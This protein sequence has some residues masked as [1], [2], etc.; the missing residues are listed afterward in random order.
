LDFSSKLRATNFHV[1]QFYVGQQ[2]ETRE[3]VKIVG[4]GKI[5][6][7]LKQDFNYWDFD[8]FFDNLPADCKPDGGQNIG[9]FIADFEYGLANITQV[10]SLK[11]IKS[12]SDKNK[13]L[14]VECKMKAKNIKERP[15]IDEICK[16]WREEIKFSN[17]HYKT[18]LKHFNHG[19]KFE[20]TFATWHSKYLTGK[21]FVNAE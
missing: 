2:F 11:F 9:G 14:T 20:L 7:V 4:H 10:D 15:L 16:R 21:I 1:G 17:S 13:M 6:Q 3:G 5:T 12:L 19:F 8:S 18:D